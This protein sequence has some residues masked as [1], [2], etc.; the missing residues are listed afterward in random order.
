M[1]RADSARP[2]GALFGGRFGLT[3]ACAKAARPFMA[4]GRDVELDAAIDA[5]AE[6]TSLR[7]GRTGWAVCASPSW[8][9]LSRH[10][11]PTGSEAE[12]GSQG[13]NQLPKLPVD[14]AG[15]LVTF[16]EWQRLWEGRLAGSP[17]L[18]QGFFSHDR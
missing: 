2:A 14:E 5:L 1:P 12:H 13:L 8:V 16:T 10:F 4:G 17:L 15:L 9:V 18:R 6:L 11:Q 3:A 7:I